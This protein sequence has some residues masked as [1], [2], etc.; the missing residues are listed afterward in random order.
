MYLAL[1]LS[2]V[3]RMMLGVR[4][5]PLALMWR[6]MSWDRADEAGIGG[7]QFVVHLGTDVIG[8]EGGVELGVVQLVVAKGGE[9]LI[10]A[11][12]RQ[13]ALVGVAILGCA[14]TAGR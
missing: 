3:T 4:C 8:A 5:G 13:F 1:K 14:G 12:A 11:V 9:E 6:R 10:R 7:G 2:M